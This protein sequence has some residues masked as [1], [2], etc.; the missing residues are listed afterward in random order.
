[1]TTSCPTRWSV[2]QATTSSYFP[3]FASAARAAARS[4]GGM[5]SGEGAH[6]PNGPSCMLQAAT[7]GDLVKLS[8]LLEAGEQPDFADGSG[9]FLPYAPPGLSSS[10][11]AA[12][13]NG[14]HACIRHL[15]EAK[16][17]VHLA[18]EG[19]SALSAACG[20]DQSDVANAL[21]EA[22]AH[23]QPAAPP[24]ADLAL[25]EAHALLAALTQG[26][27]PEKGRHGDCARLLIDRGVRLDPLTDRQGR[28]A[29]GV[30]VGG[31]VGAA[32]T[33]GPAFLR[34]CGDGCLA[35]VELFLAAGATPNVESSQQH[36]APGAATE[37]GSLPPWLLAR[38][39]QGAQHGPFNS[40]PLCLAYLVQCPPVVRALLRA[41]AEPLHL[42]LQSILRADHA[43]SAA[44]AE[45]RECLALVLHAARDRLVGKRVRVHGEPNLDGRWGT[46]TE[47]RRTP[48]ATPHVYP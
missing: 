4:A 32:G 34:A 8:A 23:A 29:D 18:W 9:A 10:L 47:A 27:R 37:G 22:S 33:W 38:V 6:S 19:V 30:L 25:W 39:G 14:H 24:A 17:D 31:A 5:A 15:L 42:P 3:L 1:M 46:A 20:A 40:T 12:C 44:S 36:G 11:T 45:A 21:L 28:L 43:A 48:R 13:A 16:A 2:I 41:K 26:M 7:R 35:Q